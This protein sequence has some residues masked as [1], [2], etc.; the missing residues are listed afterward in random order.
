MTLAKFYQSWG[1][2]LSEL[3][4]IGYSNTLDIENAQLSM[5][6]SFMNSE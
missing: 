5:W 4:S 6:K 1:S 2:A 3:A